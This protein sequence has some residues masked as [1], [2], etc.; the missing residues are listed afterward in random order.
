[1]V[2][3]YMKIYFSWYCNQ[4]WHLYKNTPDRWF[5]QLFGVFCG[6]LLIILRVRLRGIWSYVF[7]NPKKAWKYV[8]NRVLGNIPSF[9]SYSHWWL[10]CLKNIGQVNSL[11]EYKI[12][13]ICRK[14][15]GEVVLFSPGLKKR[16]LNIHSHLEFVSFCIIRNNNWYIFE[17]I[18]FIFII[19]TIKGIVICVSAQCG[20]L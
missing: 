3:I 8:I 2:M 10:Y 5:S 15:F 17:G 13:S 4:Q 20:S 19:R 16:Y 14:Q 9:F 18:I 12:C 6:T 11:S 7:S 1:M